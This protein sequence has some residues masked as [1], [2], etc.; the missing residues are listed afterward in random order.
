MIKLATKKK[1]GKGDDALKEKPEVTKEV[2]LF[3]SVVSV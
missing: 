1:A 2:S 3:S